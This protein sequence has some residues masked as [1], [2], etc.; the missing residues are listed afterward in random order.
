MG[1][2]LVVHRENDAFAVL[3]RDHVIRSGSDARQ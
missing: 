1:E 2:M 3:V